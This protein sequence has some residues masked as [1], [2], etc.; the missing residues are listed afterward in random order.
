MNALPGRYRRCPRCGGTR[1][2]RVARH[3]RPGT[4]RR[5]RC[6]QEYRGPI[7]LGTSI[8]ALLFGSFFT[9]AG[10]VVWF[11]AHDRLLAASALLMGLPFMLFG[12]L[13]IVQWAR[14]PIAPPPAF[15]AA[16]TEK[17]T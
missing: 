7:A 1:F 15:D 14:T 17:M 2:V 3:F 16:A 10:G 9:V 8:V 12:V 11:F 5:C 6:G 4:W 13:A